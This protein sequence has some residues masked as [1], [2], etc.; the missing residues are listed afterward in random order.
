MLWSAPK[1]DGESKGGVTLIYR[2]SPLFQLENEKVQGP[3]LITFEL[4]VGEGDL[5][6]RWF[7]V[8]AYVA[9]SDRDG[10]IARRIEELIALRPKDLQALILANLNADLDC[11]RDR[12]EEILAG[13]MARYGL[14]CASRHFVARRTRHVRGRWTYW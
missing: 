5:T 4:V 11:P 14:V 13:G 8:G 9:P 1:R 12:Q 6:E 2:D 10:S 3:S 7:V